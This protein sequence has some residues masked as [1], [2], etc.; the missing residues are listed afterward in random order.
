MHKIKIKDEF[1]WRH[2]LLFN[3]CFRFHTGHNAQSHAGGS[4]AFEPFIHQS[5][6]FRRALK[7]LTSPRVQ[8][9]V[10]MLRSKQRNC[11]AALMVAEQH[12]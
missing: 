4:S 10:A 2:Y 6:V 5:L 12:Y 11:S 7:G 9:Q 1:Y 8:C 3:I